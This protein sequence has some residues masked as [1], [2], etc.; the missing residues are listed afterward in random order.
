MLTHIARKPL[1]LFK[2]LLVLVAF[3]AV[4]F[5]ANACTSFVLSTV[6]NRRMYGRTM[7][8]GM[9][10]PT[11]IGLYPRGYKFQSQVNDEPGYSWAGKIAVIGAS[12]FDQPAI[13]DGVNEFGLSGGALYFPGFAGYKNPSHN[14][15]ERTREITQID[16][17]LWILTNFKTVEEVKTHL[18]QISLVGTYFAPMGLVPPLHYTLH[19]A[20]GFSLVIEPVNGELK[21]YDNPYTVLTNSPD[22]EWQTQNIRNYLFLSPFNLG[23]TTIM[24]QDLE[25]FGQG[26]GLLGIPGDP[27]PP[28]R[29]IRALGFVSSVDAAA[30]NKSRLM[31][32]VH[33]LN[34]FDIPKGFVRPTISPTVQEQEDND[35][36]QWSS[37]ADLENRAYFIKTYENQTL[38]TVSFDD[39]DV[40]GSQ[41]RFI[42]LPPRQPTQKLLPAKQ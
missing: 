2:L 13:V 7:E 36:T 40:S 3:I 27:T 29:F 22:F 25:P 19:D 37:I 14:K 18:D 32:M 31:T 41:I 10:V 1:A 9:K 15:E 4:P 5:A 20:A 17:L 8:F 12:V 35:Y 30:L 26:S 16:F 38:Y 42:D 11:K 28:S 21:V 24:G 39:F 33:V 6:D 34:N 23:S